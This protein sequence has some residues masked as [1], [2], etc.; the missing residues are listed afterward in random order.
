MKL[1]PGQA[2]PL[3]IHAAALVIFTTIFLLR[4][5]Y[6]FLGY[7]AVIL[8]FMWL[9]VYT[10]NK[11]NYPLALVW[12][13]T[14]WSIMH[15]SGGGI[16][17]SGKKLYETMIFN[18][19]GEPYFIFKYD[20]LVHI[21]GFGVATFAMYTLLNPILRPS[22][23]KISLAIVVIMAGLGV[24]ALNEIIEFFMTVFMA[25]NGVGG[26]VNNSIDLVANLIGATIAG[27]FIVRKK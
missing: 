11:V 18:I 19:V 5:N 6:E 8:F 26:Y 16:L 9:I 17:I 12:G 10:N 2:L 15:M 7:V 21:I 25:N 22:S 3:I 27:I 4:K 23:R 24:G 13:L 20:Q 1:K 14:A